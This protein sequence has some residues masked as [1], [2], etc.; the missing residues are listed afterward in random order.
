[1]CLEPFWRPVAVREMQLFRGGVAT[2]IVGERR[3]ALAQALELGASL[4]DQ[5]VLVDGASGSFMN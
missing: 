4:R 5:V 3:A 2:K 1:M